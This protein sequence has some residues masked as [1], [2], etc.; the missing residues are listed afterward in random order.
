MLSDTST[1]IRLGVL[2]VTTERAPRD[3]WGSPS[4]AQILGSIAR[5]AG[6]PP[7]EGGLPGL[8]RNPCGPSPK[9]ITR[10]WW[11]ARNPPGEPLKEGS[12][13]GASLRRLADGHMTSGD[14]AFYGG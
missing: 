9:P 2:S 6:R 13:G 7:T 8:S 10:F 12:V 4:A 14:G 1:P 5:L 11:V 3:A